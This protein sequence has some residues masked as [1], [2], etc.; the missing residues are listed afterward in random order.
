[1]RLVAI[2]L[3][4]PMIVPSDA[5][6]PRGDGGASGSARVPSAA[7]AAPRGAA[8]APGGF[9]IGQWRGVDAN[10]RIMW[11]LA[12]HPDLDR[13]SQSAIS[14]AASNTSSTLTL[15]PARSFETA[16]SPRWKTP[17]VT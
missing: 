14:Y 2:D 3:N 7:D 10:N 11:P 12:D 16:R 13:P 15:N 9:G 4:W 5:P 1:M 17:W 8:D 6:A